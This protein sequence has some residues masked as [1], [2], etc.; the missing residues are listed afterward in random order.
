MFNT[1][2]CEWR[3]GVFSPCREEQGSS[4]PALAVCTLVLPTGWSHTGVAALVPW[5]GVHV[6]LVVWKLKPD[7]AG[8]TCQ[9]L[10]WSPGEFG[11]QAERMLSFLSS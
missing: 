6:G 2:S 4:Q 9:G 1:G 3:Y 7:K 11:N 5:C 10:P 8:Q